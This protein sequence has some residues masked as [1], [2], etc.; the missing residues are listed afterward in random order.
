MP[1]KVLKVQP[2]TIP[3]SKAALQALGEEELNQFQR[4]SLEYVTKFSKIDPEAARK[5]VDEIINKFDI[6]DEEAVQIVNCMPN[7]IEEMR[8][9]LAA[10]R[11]IVE[12]STLNAIL[13]TINKY[14]TEK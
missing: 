13:E 3:E 10:G 9:F 4:R 1:K 6:S 12:T 8:V 14:R 2:I 11:R 5:L 7:S